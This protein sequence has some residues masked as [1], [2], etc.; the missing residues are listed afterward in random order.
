MCTRALSLIKAYVKCDAV[1]LRM[2]EDNDYPYFVNEGL[3]QE[4]IELENHLPGCDQEGDGTTNPDGTPVLGCMCA[5]VLNARFDRSKP[6]FTNKGSFWTNSISRLVATTT[7]EDRGGATCKACNEHGY[8]SVA[9]VPIESDGQIIGLLQINAERRNLFSLSGIQFLEEL[10][11]LIRA[12]LERKN[13]EQ[14]LRQSEEKFRRIAEQG[15]DVVLSADLD[16][17]LTYASPSAMRVFGYRPDEMVGRN[18]AELIPESGVPELS[19]QLEEIAEG[20]SFSGREVE[21]RCKDGSVAIVELNAAPIRDGE[22]TIGALA[23]ARDITERRRVEHALRESEEKYRTLVESAGESIASINADGKFLF[24]NTTAAERLG[25]KPEDYVGKRMWDLFPKEIADRQMASVRGVIETL[26]GANVIVPTVLQGQI[27]WYNTTIEPLTV[28]DADT[29]NAVMMIARDIHDMKQA[30]EELAMYREKMAHADRLASLG[31]L[32]ATVAH[33]LTQPLT[34]VR[35]TLDNL[36]D[37]LKAASSPETITTK[38]EDS[39]AEISNITSIIDRFRSFARKSSEASVARVNLE[40]V[41]RRITQLLDQSARRARIALHITDMHQ[42]PPVH[43]NERDFEQLIFALAENAIQAADGEKPRELVI[44]GQVKDGTIEL[45][46][47]DDCGG[48]AP[49]NLD[50]VLEP[51]FT[52]K[53][54]GQGTGLGLSIVQQIAS[55]AGGKVSVESEFGKGSTFIVTLP[56]DTSR[57]L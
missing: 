42:L 53:P 31:T 19:L 10:G 39:L 14:A 38:I 30:E 9:L 6:F 33:E 4:F 7:P 11:L 46:F 5:V 51:F 22:K 54:P 21:V 44:S 28:G 15:F 43:I 50:A 56:V 41:A 52:T 34:V 40:T 2:K 57:L 27:R 32:S 1:A 16:G 47:A 23:N 35:L 20:K 55:R 8:E 36:L 29:A 25:G 45:R 17:R 24:M 18:A 13:A 26:R 12:A 37:D 49:E 48:I 3:S